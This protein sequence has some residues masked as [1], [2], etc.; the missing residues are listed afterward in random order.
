MNARSECFRTFQECRSRPLLEVRARVEACGS[1]SK[2]ARALS[3]RTERDAFARTFSLWFNTPRCDD[4]CTGGRR[5]NA[6]ESDG[7]RVSWLHLLFVSLH[8]WTRVSAA[9]GTNLRERTRPG[10]PWD[11]MR[12]RQSSRAREAGRRRRHRRR[13]N[14]RLFVVRQTPPLF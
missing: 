1:V 3:V 11:R 4:G 6:L 5:D 9:Y 14:R 2:D 13:A 8:C 7:V 12:R 10:C